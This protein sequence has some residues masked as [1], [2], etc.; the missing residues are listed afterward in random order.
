[1]ILTKLRLTP[2][3]LYSLSRLPYHTPFTL[4]ANASLNKLELAVV[5]VITWAEPPGAVQ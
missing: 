1:M 2:T 3:V 5:I 4:T